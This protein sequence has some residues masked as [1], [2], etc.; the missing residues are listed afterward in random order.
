MP[1]PVR[2]DSSSTGQPSESLWRW[3]A[4][5]RRER[6]MRSAFVAIAARLYPR[7][8]IQTRAAT[9]DSRPGWR[10]STTRMTPRQ[11]GTG[12][13][14]RRL[15]IHLV[16]EPTHELTELP[17]RLGP[18]PRVAVARKVRDQKGFA[19][20]T[21][22]R[23]P[24]Q[25]EQSGRARLRAGSRDTTLHQRV[26]QARLADVRPSNQGDDRKIVG[27]QRPTGDDAGDELRGKGAHLSALLHPRIRADPLG[28]HSGSGGSGASAP[29]ERSSAPRPSCRPCRG[30]AS[31]GRSSGCQTGPSRCP[32][33]G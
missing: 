30:R 17:L 26:D 12:I 27:Q 21:G 10:T 28:L 15:P 4:V 31:R 22:G 32:S 29:P 2:V 9:S 33:V 5:C 23:H 20:G 16:E 11:A 25:V 14:I 7:S 18:P 6:A 13:A 8:P 3:R 1:S 24:I 19:L